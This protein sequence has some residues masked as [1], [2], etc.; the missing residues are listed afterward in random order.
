MTAMTPEQ[1]ILLTALLSTVDWIAYKIEKG[2]PVD[3]LVE[4][5]CELETEFLATYSRQSDAD[6][7][8]CSRF[9]NDCE[10]FTA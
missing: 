7:D 6:L 2:L 3:Y 8:Y 5:A 4:Q 9:A 10:G 1:R